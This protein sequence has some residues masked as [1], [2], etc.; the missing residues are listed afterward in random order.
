MIGSKMLQLDCVTFRGADHW[1]SRQL[2]AIAQL[3]TEFSNM[4]MRD[5]CNDMS[6]GMVNWKK[7]RAWHSLVSVFS[8]QVVMCLLFLLL[9][10]LEM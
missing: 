10:I 7:P 8:L 5:N 4:P 9:S 1:R 6:R 2:K 3:T